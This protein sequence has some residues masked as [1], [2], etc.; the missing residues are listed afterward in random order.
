MLE[1]DVALP[2]GHAQSAARVPDFAGDDGAYFAEEDRT[3][4]IQLR[5]RC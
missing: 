2:G 1:A 4:S 5:H 3:C